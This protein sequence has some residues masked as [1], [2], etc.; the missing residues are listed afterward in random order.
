MTKIKAVLDQNEGADIMVI[1]NKHKPNMETLI[2]LEKEGCRC[3]NHI[4]MI[5]TEAF[6]VIILDVE[7]FDMEM[8]TR[9]RNFLFFI[10]DIK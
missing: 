3:F 2:W 5:G 1:Y 7:E 10:T 8:V 6:M 4:D 9:S